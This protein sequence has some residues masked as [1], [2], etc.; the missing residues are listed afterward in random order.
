MEVFGTRPASQLSESLL[1]QGA[2]ALSPAPASPAM[3]FPAVSCLIARGRGGQ[4][5][6][7][8]RRR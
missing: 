2:S 3:S 8:A 7:G 5:L 6:F 4:F 1:A